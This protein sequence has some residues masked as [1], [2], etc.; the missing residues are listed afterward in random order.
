MDLNLKIFG[1]KLNLTGLS[2]DTARLLAALSFGLA[3]AAMLISPLVVIWALNTL[4]PNLAIAPGF[5]EWLAVLALQVLVIG[6]RD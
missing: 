1:F 6:N 3:I 5:W 4:F 2:G